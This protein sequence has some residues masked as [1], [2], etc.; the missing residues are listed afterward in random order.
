LTGALLWT[1]GKRTLTVRTP[2]P[3]AKVAKKK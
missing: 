1:L 3:L 2:A